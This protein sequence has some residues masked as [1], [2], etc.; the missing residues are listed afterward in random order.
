MMV[1][2]RQNFEK[3]CFV[4]DSVRLLWFMGLVTQECYYA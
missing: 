4:V 2:A 3:N 1:L